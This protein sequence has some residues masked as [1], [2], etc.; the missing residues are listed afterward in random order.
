[1]TETVI[2]KTP[3]SGDDYYTVTVDN[4][5]EIEVSSVD[6]NN[7][8]V[9]WLMFLSRDEAIGMANAILK[10]YQ[11]E[12]RIPYNSGDIDK[13]IDAIKSASAG[14]LIEVNA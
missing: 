3:L 11:T 9:E 1:M 4:R 6:G 5:D 12:I 7:G 10:H 14:T 8:D 13:I 2:Y